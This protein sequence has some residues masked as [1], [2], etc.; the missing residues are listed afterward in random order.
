MAR[1]PKTKPKTK[2]KADN[3]KQEKLAKQELAKLTRIIHGAP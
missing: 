2:P 1:K 3:L